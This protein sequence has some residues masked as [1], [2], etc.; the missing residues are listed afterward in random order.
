[1]ITFIGSSC[2]LCD[3]PIRRKISLC[4]PCQA[5]LP[6]ITHAC[7]ICGIP[8]NN[9]SAI[10]CGQCLKSPPAFDYCISLYHY[11]TPIDYLISRL[12]F[13]QQLAYAE[14]L[15]S[16]LTDHLLTM[17]NMEELPEVLLPVPLHKKRLIKRGFNQSLEIAKV[18]SKELN[19]PISYQLIERDKATK[20]QSKL[21]IKQRKKN[22]KGCFTL[23]KM[24]DYQH[25]AIIDDVVTTGSTCNELANVLK[26]AGVKKVGVWSIARAVLHGKQG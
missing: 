7:S 2:V 4:E 5:D 15:G 18:I 24:P 21:N 3:T 11:E 25:I 22:I 1:M 20:A 6:K 10:I 23:K 26:V 8:L 16:L 9:D 12:K 14:I 17:K 19:I 13:S